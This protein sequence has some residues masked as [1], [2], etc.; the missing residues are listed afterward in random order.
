MLTL[1]VFVR[2]HNIY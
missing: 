2:Q 1:V